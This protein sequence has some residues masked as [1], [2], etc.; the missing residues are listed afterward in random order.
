LIL[1]SAVYFRAPPPPGCTCF[2][3]GLVG[4]IIVKNLEA[5][6]Q[7]VIFLV[8]MAVVPGA[9]AANADPNIVVLLRGSG[10]LMAEPPIDGAL[11]YEAELVNAQTDATIGSGVDCLQ[12]ITSVGDGFALDRTTFM[13]F[14]SGDLVAAGPTTVMPFTTNAL[15]YTHVVGDLPDATVNSIVDGTRRFA[16]RTG[17]VRLSGAVGMADFPV[18]VLFNCIFI[19]D[20]D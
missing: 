2:S 4:V 17:R 6:T 19:I 7:L 18:S 16:G 8:A 11:C 5:F 14:P 15:P 10:E 3:T 1:E 13:Y 12:N 20:M 9:G